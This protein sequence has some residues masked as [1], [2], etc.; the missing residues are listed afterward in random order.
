MKVFCD[1]TMCHLVE[2][3]PDELSYIVYYDEDRGSTVVK[4]TCYKSEDRWFDPSW[5]QWNFSLT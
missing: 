2:V 5:C 3:K 1:A 4:V